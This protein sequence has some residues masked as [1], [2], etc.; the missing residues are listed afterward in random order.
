LAKRRAAVAASGCTK[1]L[2]RN[3][4][5]EFSPQGEARQA[6]AHGQRLQPRVGGQV[7]L[8]DAHRPPRARPAAPGALWLAGFLVFSGCRRRCASH[9]G[10]VF[11]ADVAGDVAAVEAAGLEAV[12]RRVQRPTTRFI[13]STSW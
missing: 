1:Q 10:E 12:D 13:A 9:R 4:A 2:V 6:L 7:E 8:G 5:S 11:R 3:S